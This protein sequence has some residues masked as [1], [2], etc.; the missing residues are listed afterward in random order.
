MWCNSDAVVVSLEP[1]S[2]TVA[3]ALCGQ[4]GW[5]YATELSMTERMRSLKRA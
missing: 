1:S 3:H 4:L 5:D 2:K